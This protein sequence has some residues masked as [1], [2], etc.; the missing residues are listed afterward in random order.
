MKVLGNART[1]GHT[2]HSF[3]IGACMGCMFTK[4]LMLPPLTL[5]E[6]GLEPDAGACHGRERTA[7]A[8][9]HS[10]GYRRI[11]RAFGRGIK[12]GEV[13]MGL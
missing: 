7:C 5:W 4:A 10:N 12:W 13:H 1:Q 9:K 6:E 11:W 2:I 3:D 8:P